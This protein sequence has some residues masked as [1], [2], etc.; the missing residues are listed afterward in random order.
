MSELMSAMNP[1]P[2]TA[3]ASELAFVPCRVAA[4]AQAT[5]DALAIASGDVHLTYRELN[6]RADRLACYLRGVGAGPEVLVAVCL[7]RSPELIVSALGVLKAGGAYL[8]LDP[9]YPGDRISTILADAKAPLLLT[10]ECLA[11]GL[12]AGP[13]RVCSLPGSDPEADPEGC[14]QER[15][16]EQ[17]RAYVIYTSGSTGNPKGV[18]IPHGSLLNLVT[19]HQ[20]AFG[21]G[22]RDR[23]ALVSSPGFD[24]AVW[25]IWPYL[26]A[27]A[28]VHFV[29]DAT[30]VTPEG[31]RDWVVEAGITMC[32]LPAQMAEAVIHLKWPQESVLR[33]L[34]TGADV[35]H[36]YPPE[37][38]PF[39][40]VNNYGPTECT[41]VSTSGWLQPERRGEHPPTIGRP[42]SNT[43]VHIL[44]EDL[45]PVAPGTTGELHVGGSGLARGYLNRPDATAERYIPDPFSSEPGAR[46][47]KT[48]DM[49]RHLPDGQ[50]LFFGRSDDQVKVR[51]HRVEIGE[52]DA[53]LREFEGVEDC[54]V[55]VR[56]ISPGD[57]RIRAYVVPAPGASLSA[58][59]L[60]DFLI[61]KLPEPMIPTAWIRLTALP[62][63]A[64]GKVDRSALPEPDATN[65]MRDD[66]A[67]P[68]TL[69]EECLAEILAPLLGVERVGTEDNFFF[70]GGHSLLG[71]QVIARVRD[72]FGVELSLLALFDAPTVAH[73]AAE[74][75]KLIV[76]GLEENRVRGL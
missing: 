16:S 2:G 8:P 25:E 31:L 22:R 58:K 12:P 65:T 9:T 6:H 17:Q 5:P 45:R 29:A 76:E 73:L 43:R 11:A 60:R 24:A 52:I 53:L 63:T 28:S 46:L 4:W 37:D 54:L 71:A 36:R 57:R 41:V 32:F 3:E 19:W 74:I 44:G 40:V 68:R 56:E 21:V 38:L 7:P 33:F 70:L 48:G 39:V 18:Q 49:G 14:P 42:I 34:L 10:N 27:G 23:A 26:T 15:P 75:E 1:S 66:I 69:V 67:P 61:T 20:E 72:T 47:Y 13:W 64:H 55:L 35:V 51:G 30:R 50:I 59:A 62:L